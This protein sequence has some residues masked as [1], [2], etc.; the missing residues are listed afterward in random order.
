MRSLEILLSAAV[1]AAALTQLAHAGTLTT[2]NLT[3]DSLARSYLEYRP[4]TLP[5][6][7]LPLVVVLH[8]GSESAAVAAGSTRASFHWRVVADADGVVL[9][10]PEGI[11]GN[12]NDCGQTALTGTPSS[13]DDVGFLRKVVADMS[14]RFT[15]DQQRIYVSGASNGGLMSLRLVQEA[16][17]TFAGAAAFIALN[18]NDAAGECRSP[19]NPSTVL[20]QYG[21]VDPIIQ[22][23]GG[24]RNQSAAA[25]RTYWSSRLACVGAP[26]L[27]DYFD[28]NTA[29]G[30]TVS[31]ERFQ[32][33][34]DGSS[35]HI[36]TAVGAGHT[37]PSVLYASGGNQNR[38][39]EAVDEAWKVLKEDVLGIDRWLAT[40]F[41]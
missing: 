40:S 35:L 38:D 16:S 14:G 33:C 3:H 17:E 23:G 37:T 19:A 12:W 36:L 27:E 24:P 7:P 21:S 18:A 9:A 32:S 26:L 5:T 34:A 1:C 10:Y 20:Y 31:A 6:T 29:D 11:L 15:I 41:E 4:T 13:A 25:T 2:R 30:S 8:G 28:A 39:I 22:P